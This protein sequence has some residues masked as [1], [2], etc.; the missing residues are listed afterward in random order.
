[1]T[2]TVTL[3]LST[4]ATE[5][6]AVELVDVLADR[7]AAVA[8]GG[9]A[10][11][12]EVT[13]T[14]EGVTAADALKDATAAVLWKAIA[15]DLEL[16]EG[17]AVVAAEVMTEAEQDLRLADDPFPDLAG[18]AEA[19]DRLGLSRQRASTLSRRDDFPSPV[20]RLAATP[21][22]RTADLDTFAQGWARKPGRPPKQTT[23]G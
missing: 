5:Q 18:V 1:M 6:Q 15:V 10:G 12:V 2:W 11:Q 8:T 14:A 20:A 23:A 19:A 16:E 3:T 9:A 17:P 13:L 7:G 4:A 21:V 22:W